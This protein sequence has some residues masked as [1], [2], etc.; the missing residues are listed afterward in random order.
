V[1]KKELVVC[2]TNILIEVIDRN[3]KETINAL[4]D[5]GTSKLCISSI[6]YSEMILGAKSKSHLSKLIIELSRFPVIPLSPSIDLFHRDLLLRYS[7]SHGLSIPDALIAASVIATDCKLYTLNK[8]D[9]KFIDG[10][11]L[12]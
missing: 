9:F 8:K 6:S 10:L 5:I 12:I 11:D 7:L 3:N 4:I 1:E 2:D